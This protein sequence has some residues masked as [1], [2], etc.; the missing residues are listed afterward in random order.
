MTLAFI[1][2]STGFWGFLSMD[3][4]RTQKVPVYVTDHVKLGWYSAKK[5]LDFDVCIE[6]SSNRPF[7]GHM[8][9]PPLHL[10]PG[11]L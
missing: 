2:V 7:A 5:A 4:M 11:T 6:K 9:Y 10:K 3:K 1:A 8:T